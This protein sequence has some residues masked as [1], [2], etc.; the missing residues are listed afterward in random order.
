MKLVWL[1][2]KNSTHAARTEVLEARPDPTTIYSNV[3]ERRTSQRIAWLPLPFFN[4]SVPSPSSSP[5]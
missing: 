2:G 4:T 1:T 5:A 3:P